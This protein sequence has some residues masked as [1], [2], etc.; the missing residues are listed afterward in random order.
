MVS[1]QRRMPAHSVSV[2][3][4]VLG[5]S[6]KQIVS[7]DKV[8]SLESR[9]EIENSLKQV[10][11]RSLSEDP[12]PLRCFCSRCQEATFWGQIRLKLNQT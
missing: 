1:E 10:T 9:T 2:C 11:A 12:S 5:S 3:S 8:F 4:Y 6:E 7:E